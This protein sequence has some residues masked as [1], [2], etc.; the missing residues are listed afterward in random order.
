MQL[1]KFNVNAVPLNFFCMEDTGVDT[2]IDE[3]V[4]N[5]NLYYCPMIDDFILFFSSTQNFL[6]ICCTSSFIIC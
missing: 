5:D 6:H 2:S 1:V 4:Q 3:L